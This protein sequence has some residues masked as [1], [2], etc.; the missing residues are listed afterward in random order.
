METKEWALVTFTI[1]SQTAVGAY[2]ILWISQLFYRG[3]K[4]SEI[5]DKLYYRPFLVILPLLLVGLFASSTHLGNIQNSTN[6]INNVKTS[7]LSREILFNI[8]FTGSVI[9]YI[10]VIWKKIGGS[11]LHNLIGLITSIF[12]IALV[13]SMASVYMIKAVPIWNTINT[14]FSFM[15]TTFL[16]GSL[17]AGAALFSSYRGLSKKKA[18]GIEE[19]QDLLQKNIRW[20]SLIGMIMIGILLVVSASQLSFLAA[21]PV[22]GAELLYENY[23]TLHIIRLII[24]LMGAGVLSLFLYNATEKSDKVTLMGK[25]VYGALVILLIAEVIGRF[26]FYATF[27]RIGI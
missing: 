19:Y 6:A 10:Y 4:G 2:I 22:P 8:L 21:N 13:Y 3:K 1:L 20:I 5:S 24:I 27:A 11:R 15:A 9:I 18:N 23:K 16:L 7:W 26:L 14:I 17:C 12:G 25:Y